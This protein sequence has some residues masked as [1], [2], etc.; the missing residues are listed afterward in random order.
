MGAPLLQTLCTPMLYTSPTWAHWTGCVCEHFHIN[1]CTRTRKTCGPHTLLRCVCSQSPQHPRTCTGV[2]TQDSC[3]QY[4]TE[5]SM[6]RGYETVILHYDSEGCT[7]ALMPR[8]LVCACYPHITPV[9]M[10]SFCEQRTYTCATVKVS[11]NFFI[12]SVFVPTVQGRP[13]ATV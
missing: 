10:M 12:R 9:S 8:A 1:Q 4:R 13:C 5:E 7:G 11:T 3:V 2:A 6:N